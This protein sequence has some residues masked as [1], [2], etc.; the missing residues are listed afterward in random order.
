MHRQHTADDN[1][2]RNLHSNSD[3]QEH[4]EDREW[5]DDRQIHCNLLP[6]SK[7]MAYVAWNLSRAA[8][9]TVD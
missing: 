5:A 4:W 1:D 8:V 6:N 7:S 3:Y 2:L 9:A